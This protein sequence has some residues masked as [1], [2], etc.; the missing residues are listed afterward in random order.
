VNVPNQ[1]ARRCDVCVFGFAVGGKRLCAVHRKIYKR[2]ARRRRGQPGAPEQ[3]ET[4]T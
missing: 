3:S 4:G 2:M 1:P